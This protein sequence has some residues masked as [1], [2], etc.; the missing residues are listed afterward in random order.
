MEFPRPSNSLLSQE[1]KN[2][3][4]DLPP[5]VIEYI[6]ANPDRELKLSFIPKDLSVTKYFEFKAEKIQAV[7]DYLEMLFHY[8]VRK[9]PRAA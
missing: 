3:L 1:E 2:F 6:M 9:D 5:Q 7:H 4:D 8:G